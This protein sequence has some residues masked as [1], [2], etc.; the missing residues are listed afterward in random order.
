MYRVEFVVP[1]RYCASAVDSC[2]SSI[3]AEINLCI[4]YCRRPCVIRSLVDHKQQ[5]FCGEGRGDRH[6][7]GTGDKGP[8]IR[9]HARKC[10]A[11]G[12]IEVKL[13]NVRT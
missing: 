4:E 8:Y 13:F 12:K 5:C 9:F 11:S 7:A 10:S 3:V 1:T 2:R 6:L